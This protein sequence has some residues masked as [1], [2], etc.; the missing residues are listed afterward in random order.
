MI[1]AIVVWI[2]A[3]RR[4]TAHI[5][6]N[7]AARATAFITLIDIIPSRGEIARD[8]FDRAIIPVRGIWVSFDPCVSAPW[9]VVKIIC[10]STATAGAVAGCAVATIVVVR[11]RW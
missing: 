9:M 5:F 4:R 1:S 7:G 11:H 8:F 10:S 3:Y 6:V 2:T